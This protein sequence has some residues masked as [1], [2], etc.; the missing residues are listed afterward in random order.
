M[1][2]HSGKAG[3]DGDTSDDGKADEVNDGD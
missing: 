1:L 2:A 3:S